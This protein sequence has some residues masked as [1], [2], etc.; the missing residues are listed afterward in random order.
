MTA[1][2]AHLAEPSRSTPVVG[3]YEV[4]VIGGGPAGVMAAVAAARTG[5]STILVERYGFL[6]GA[7]SAGGLSTFCGL[8]ANVHGEH[9]QVVHGLADDL[10]ERMDGLGGLNPPHLSFANRIMAQAYDI[11]TYKIAADDLLVDAG[12]KILF[13]ALAVG[14]VTAP[15]R[16]VQAVL[17]ESKS[18]RGAITGQ[19]FIDCSGDGDLAAWAGAPYEKTDKAAGMMYPSLM[20]RINGVDHV[21]AGQ[22]WEQLP[23]LMDEAESSGSTASRASD[24]SSAR[25]ATRWSG[26]RT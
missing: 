7:G 19:M 1:Q 8:H 14:V 23:G 17:I 6:G 21:A 25:S 13:H 26:G 22:A 10:L 4:V 20:F 15:D 2:T 9:R 11:S 12:A 16:R 3:D 18:G 5:R 24:P